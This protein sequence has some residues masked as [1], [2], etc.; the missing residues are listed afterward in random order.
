L[1]TVEEH[2]QIAAEGAAA[3]I[4]ISIVELGMVI[5]QRR[6]W[7]AMVTGIGMLL[8]VGYALLIPNQYTSTAQLMPPD[9]RALSNTFMLSALAGAGAIGPSVGG[10]MNA[11]TPGGTFIGILDSQTAQDDIINR[12]DLRRVYHCKFYTDARN[13][14]KGKTTIVEDKKSGIISISVTDRDPNQARDLAEANVEELNKLVNSLSTSSARR[15]REFLEQ[16]LKSIKSDLDASSVALSQF[17]SRNATMNPQS[18]GQALFESATRLQ[19]ALITAQSELSGLK[20]M[21]S[22]DNMRVREARARIDELQSQLRKMGGISGKVDGA[23]QKSNKLYPSIRELPLLG[24]T[25]SDL[26]RQLAMQVGIYE[27][28]TKQYELAKVEEA[29]EIPP[30]KVLD[31]PDVPERKSSPHRAIIVVLGFL[32][33][34]FAGITWILASALW[35]L[36]NGFHSL[37]EAG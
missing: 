30:I 12:F 16:R 8:A 9:Q 33:S 34:A 28:L 19:G 6:R 2:D 21:Y 5:W 7:L 31:E 14:L 18:Q 17:S 1:S 25:Y 20:A 4:E 26:S 10:L 29:K 11:R 23:D 3:P 36:T 13:I 24:V 35:D 27:T 32:L 15:E 22:D 37:K